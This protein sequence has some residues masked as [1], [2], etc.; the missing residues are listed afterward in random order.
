MQFTFPTGAV[1][2]SRHFRSIL[3]NIGAEVFRLLSQP[4]LLTSLYIDD[5]NDT[6]IL[7]APAC[8]C[9]ISAIDDLAVAVTELFIQ[10]NISYP[11]PVFPILVFNNKSRA[12]THACFQV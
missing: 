5:L 7:P 9:F 3:R 4:P 8:I 6:I 11:Q 10:G 1:L 2:H 12:M